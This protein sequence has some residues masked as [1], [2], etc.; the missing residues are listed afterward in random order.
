MIDY[1]T[2][3]VWEWIAEYAGTRDAP[4]DLDTICSAGVSLT[5]M[6]GGWITRGYEPADTAFAT[7]A[8]AE[9][10][11]DLQ[12]VLGEGPATDAGRHG[13]PV[14]VADLSTAEARRAWPVFTGAAIEAG[15][16]AVVVVPMRVAEAT[17]GLFGLYSRVPTDLVASQR[18][19]V[20]AFA[21]VA[22]GLMLD[23]PHPP[24]D[25]YRWH[26]G[27]WS[28]HCPEIHQATGIV[29]V[30]LGVDVAE[31]LVRL[32]AHAYAQAR[33][34]SEIAREVVTRRLCFTPE[35]PNGPIEA[36]N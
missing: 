20:D 32:R 19:E 8:D 6:T 25:L 18:A 17:I 31:S 3:R 35:L 24:P 28:L 10:L 23:G 4:L 26:S 16:R 2:L 22:L 30:Q 12:F 21:D 34:L 11:A 29:S 14:A 1:R 36:H 33:P 15:T 7:D 5:G 9:A 13:R 27:G